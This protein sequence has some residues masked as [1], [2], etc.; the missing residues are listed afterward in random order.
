M[1]PNLHY[2][3]RSPGCPFPAGRQQRKVHS[4]QRFACTLTATRLAVSVALVGAAAAASTGTPTLTVAE[5]RFPMQLPSFRTG[6]DVVNVGITVTDRKGGLVADLSADDFEIYED[7]RKQTIR[8]FAAGRASGAGD[9]AMHLGLLLDVSESMNEDIRFT[10]TAAVKFL[11]TLVEAADVTVVDFDAE[12]RV[13]RYGQ[14]DMARL[15]ERIRRQKVS[16]STALYDAI[17]VYLDGAAG[18]DGRKVMLLYTDGADT[19]SALQFREL[20]DLLKTSDVTVYVIGQIGHEPPSRR[21]EQRFL[22]QEIADLTGGQAFFPTTVK[23]LDVVY[24]KVVNQ[25]RAQYTLGYVTTNDK[26]DGA[27]R[28]VAIKVVRKDGRVYRVRSRKGYFAPR[29]RRPPG[30]P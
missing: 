17:G 23:E 21:S 1:T 18:L 10:K 24:D 13:T 5:A 16:G 22:L 8:Y 14:S 3:P 19:E 9:P 29:E 2:T 15:I 30:R 7:G 28:K 26:T 25:V 27:W 6:I 12:V 11:N 20:S 4:L